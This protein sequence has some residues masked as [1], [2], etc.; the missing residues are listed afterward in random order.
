[1]KKVLLLLS[2]CFL[3]KLNAQFLLD[4]KG[5][6]AMN[7]IY[8]SGSVKA[9]DVKMYEKKEVFEWEDSDMPERVNQLFFNSKS[10]SVMY[11]I[12]TLTDNALGGML[13]NLNRD[14][15]VV[16]RNKVWTTVMNGNIV[17]VTLSRVEYFKKYNFDFTIAK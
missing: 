5:G 13:A 7:A 6:D 15:T 8:K 4:L 14:Y 2:L 12:T 9:V 11:R 16:S 3:Q 1:M 17:K 10:I